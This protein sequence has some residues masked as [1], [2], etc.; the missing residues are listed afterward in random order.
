MLKIKRRK[1]WIVIVA[2]LLIGLVFLCIKVYHAGIVV[3]QAFN[4]SFN[5]DLP[6]T[7]SLSSEDSS[8][9]EPRYLSKLKVIGIYN[10]KTRNP[11]ALCNF[12]SNY[13]LIIYK[14]QLTSSTPL[15]MLLS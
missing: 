4:K 1:F 11:I 15:K 5:E 6:T 8:L 13:E 2:S 10:S 12:D 9:I 7:Y 14:I 3:G